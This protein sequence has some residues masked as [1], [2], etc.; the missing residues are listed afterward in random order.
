MNTLPT[1]YIG[2]LRNERQTIRILRRYRHLR[3][4]RK[5]IIAI[6]LAICCLPL[7]GGWTT[8]PDSEAYYGGAQPISYY[9]NSERID[10]IQKQVITDI[11]TA[12]GAPNYY[13]DASLPNGCGAAAGATI[14]GFYDKYMDTIKNWNSTLPNG[15]YKKQDSVYVAKIMQDLFTEMKT[16]T[17]QSGITENDFKNGLYDYTH[18][19]GFDVSY[20][21]F[22]SGNT[23]N[24]TLMKSAFSNNKVVVLF[25][26]PDNLYSITSNSNTDTISTNYI[27]ANH[28]LIAYGY[29]E[30]QYTLS[31]G[32]R[33][34]AYLYVSPCVNLATQ[35]YYKV[36]SSLV[37]AYIVNIY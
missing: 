10:Y 28:I 3:D 15:I 21:Y 5:S 11:K 23:I 8:A 34:D 6:L 31:S 35:Q 22:G 13:P 29:Y 7:C 33:T 19:L 4:L 27:S 2:G 18:S 14:L 12:N 36:T 24:Y 16:N 17:V 26:K 30:I 20:E 37:S 1:T 25:I 32:T 9:A